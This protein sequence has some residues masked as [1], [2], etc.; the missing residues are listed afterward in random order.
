M[1]K[2]V[3]RPIHKVVMKVFGEVGEFSSENLR[4]VADFELVRKLPVSKWI[5]YFLENVL[6]GWSG[7][8]KESA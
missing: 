2:K 3:S 4:E 5:R 7:K 8:L 6:E 1:D